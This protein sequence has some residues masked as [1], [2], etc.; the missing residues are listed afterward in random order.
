MFITP[1]RAARALAIPAAVSV[2]LAFGACGT[3]NAD[4]EKVRAEGAKLQQQGEVI[5]KE[6]AQTA[7]DVKSGKL[8]A[9]EAAKKMRVASDKITGQ[10]KDAASGAIDA[11]SADALSDR[12]HRTTEAPPGA[13]LPARWS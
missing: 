4:T 3:N 13:G 12:R 9:E 7:A 1:A 5:R 10:A 8:S 6:A 2:A 11:A